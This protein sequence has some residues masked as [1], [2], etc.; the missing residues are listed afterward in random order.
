[1]IGNGTD[2]IDVVGGATLTMTGCTV[3]GN[4]GNGVLV[5]DNSRVNLGDGS[6]RARLQDGDEERRGR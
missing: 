5:A 6:R 1:M 2:G 4:G 3:L